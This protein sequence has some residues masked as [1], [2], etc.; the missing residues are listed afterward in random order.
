MSQINYEVQP[1]DTL[2]SVAE[3][4]GH[5]GE[6]QAILESAPFLEGLDY[7]AVPAGTTVLLPADWVPR[8]YESDAAAAEAESAGGPPPDDLAGLSAA[9]LIEL[10]GEAEDS[11]WLDA[12]AEAA[13]GRVTVL[14]AV[15]AR[16]AQLA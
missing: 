4:C 2:P 9:E 7:L 14:A 16:R 3:R 1:G 13:G 15:D 11:A 5:S 10:A 6:W 8:G 12:I